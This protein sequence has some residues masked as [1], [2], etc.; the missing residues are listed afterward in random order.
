MATQSEKSDIQQLKTDVAVIKLQQKTQ[1]TTLI[2]INDKL[3][4]L[5]FVSQKD[6]DRDMADLNEQLVAARTRIT[7]LE[8]LVNAG[9]VKFVNAINSG[10]GK[11]ITAAIVLA[12]LAAIIVYVPRLFPAVGGQSSVQSNN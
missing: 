8:K 6:H 2:Q 11:A 7:D 3:D 10:V 9:G 4:N 5:A 1:G 12:I